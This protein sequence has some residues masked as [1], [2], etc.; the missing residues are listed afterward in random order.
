MHYQYLK[1]FLENSVRQ[2]DTYIP[3]MILFLVRNEG[4][5]TTEQIA[6]LMYI[7][8]YQKELSYYE[9]IVEKFAATLL[10]E[11]NIITKEDTHYHLNTWP[12]D[13]KQIEEIVT[14]CS[15]KSNGFFKH[16]Q[17][18]KETLHS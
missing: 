8:D 15:K 4:K 14:R 18:K 7:F 10:L 12:L 13:T 17:A 2:N 1:N 3:T 9:S 16:I 6:K 5:G 11:Y